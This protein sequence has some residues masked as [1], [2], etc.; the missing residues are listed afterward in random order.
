LVYAY[1][2]IINHLI[3]DAKNFMVGN[4]FPAKIG[5]IASHREGDI[6]KKGDPFFKSELLI[7]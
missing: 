2:G 4:S 6:P 7:C 5:K 1:I 3:P